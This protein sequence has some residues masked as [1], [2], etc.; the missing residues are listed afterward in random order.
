MLHGTD[1][2]LVPYSGVLR[3]S[4]RL[5][6]LGYRHR[7]YT[8]PGYEHY[9]HP[10]MDQWAEA[11]RYMHQFTRPENPAH[12]VYKRDMAFERATETVQSDGANLNFDF[13]SAYW[14]SGLT[15]VD[16]APGATTEDRVASF[17]GRSLAIP[18]EAHLAVPDSGPPT[19]PGQTGPYVI[20]GIQWLDDPASSAPP[21]SNAFDLSLT[22]AK[23]V[24]LDLPRM[25][26][27]VTQS[28]AGSVDTGA[29][30]SLRLA[31][32][33]AGT[34]SVLVDGTL[35]SATLADD[36]LVVDVPAG[37]HELTVIPAEAPQQEAT[38]L[39]FTPDSDRSAQYSDAA[40]LETSLSTVSGTPV[41]GA[42]VRFELVGA[43]SS[44]T[45]DAVTGPDGLAA[46][47]FDVTETPGEYRLTATYS[48]SDTLTAATSGMDLAIVRDDSALALTS[49]GRGANRTLSAALYDSDSAVGLAGR[50][51]SFFADGKLVGTAVTDDAG[52][53]TI[54]APPA[55]GKKAAF[56]ASFAGDELYRPS[57]DNL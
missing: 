39:Q 14:M 22:G 12:V 9:S 29:D 18:E 52:K 43:D 47:T 46:V 37:S 33:W 8:S 30:L 38:T 31:G 34:P 23:A 44:R 13:D 2:E 1:D 51:V 42:A 55:S 45:L 24:K 10:I 35:V 53:A 36:V 11:G 4:Q 5:I 6:E 56:E 21:S 32:P 7:L 15:P 41:E 48:G 25:D 50:E 19:A 27:D 57:S 40:T 26:I 20:T 28:L 54:A 3:Q 49:A 17:D 16:A